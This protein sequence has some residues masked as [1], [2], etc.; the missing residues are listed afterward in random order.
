MTSLLGL[1]HI[2][3]LRSDLGSLAREYERLGFQLTPTTRHSATDPSNP[4]GPVLPWAS[5]NRCAMFERGYLE[6]MGLVAQDGFHS[7]VTDPLTRYAGTHVIALRCADADSEHAR[8]L[9]AGFRDASVSHLHRFVEPG[10]NGIRGGLAH[11]KLVRLSH[12]ELPEARLLLIEHLT[13]E[14]LWQR[15]W[16]LHDNGSCALEDVVIATAD[17]AATRSRFELV[18]GSVAEEIEGGCR[19]LMPHGSVTLVERSGSRSYVEGGKVPCVPWVAGFSIG[20]PDLEACRHSLKA[21]GFPASPGE[22]DRITI[23]PACAGGSICRFV[24]LGTNPAYA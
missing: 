13:E 7:H 11:F 17:L 15:P 9:S 16:L 20:V 23:G 4:A 5:G 19:L 12:A 18:F 14:L 2:G 22:K 8:L 10:D 1:D 3:V 24:Q 6:L 21:R